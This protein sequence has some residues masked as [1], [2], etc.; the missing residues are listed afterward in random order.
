MKTQ[1]VYKEIF[2]VIYLKNII[3]FSK[4]YFDSN[5]RFKGMICKSFLKNLLKL[6][7]INKINKRIRIRKMELFVFRFNF[8]LIYVKLERKLEMEG[9][10]E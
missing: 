9:S 4:S 5:L 2:F 3:I 8:F 10:N 7:Q 1:L 6:N